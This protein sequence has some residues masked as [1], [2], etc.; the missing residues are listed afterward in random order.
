ML[1]EVKPAY[2]EIIVGGTRPRND[3]TTV[4]QSREDIFNIW[5]SS[6]STRMTTE[7]YVM[8]CSLDKAD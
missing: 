7:R 2:V 1:P 6:K 3:G 5:C 8:K 4:Q